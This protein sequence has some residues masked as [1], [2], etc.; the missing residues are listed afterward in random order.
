M[1]NTIEQAEACA[2]A[3]RASWTGDTALTPRGAAVAAIY[4]LRR[5][6]AQL[7]AEDRAAVMV[8]LVELAPV[9]A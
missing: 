7:G 8:L 2:A 3:M 6:L 5:A 9:V 1:L 4:R